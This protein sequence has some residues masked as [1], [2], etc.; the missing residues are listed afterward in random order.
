MRE[1]SGEPR[2]EK[3][4]HFCKPLIKV[5]RSLRAYQIIARKTG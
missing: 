3:G 4:L 1:A 2:H 5:A